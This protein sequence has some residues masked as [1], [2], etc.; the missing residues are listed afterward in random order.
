MMGVS[1]READSL[2]SEEGKKWEMSDRIGTVQMSY[3]EQVEI[4]RDRTSLQKFTGSETLLLISHFPP[5]F[6]HIIN[7]SFLVL[8]NPVG[9]V[10]EGKKHKHTEFNILVYIH[11][12]QGM[13]KWWL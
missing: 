10:S 12:L 11:I 7:Q 9:S 5:S 3:F 1:G 8:I 2:Q 13:N 4:V 6:L